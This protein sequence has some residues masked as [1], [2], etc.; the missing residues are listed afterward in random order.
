MK[1]N[2]HELKIK[3]EHFVVVMM[4]MKTAEFRVNDRNFCSGDIVNLREWDEGEYTGRELTAVI[5]DVTDC[6]PY[7]L[8]ACGIKY[9]MLSISIIPGTINN[10]TFC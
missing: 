7:I 9:A 2:R 1:P 5:T 8:G 4:G 10:R 6:S 3:P